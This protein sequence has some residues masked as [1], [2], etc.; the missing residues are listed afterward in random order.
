MRRL[1]SAAAGLVVAGGLLV[2]CNEPA[3]ADVR[4][5]IRYSG[6]PVYGQTAQEIWRDIGRK[7]PHQR[8]RGLYAQAEAEIGFGWEIA[9][10]SGG[11]ICRVE[12]ATVHADVNIILPQWVDEARGSE[13]LR[14]AWNS[15]IAEVRR[16]EDH[17]KD[18]ALV[19]AKEL[20]RAIMAA[21]AHRSCRALERY[22]QQA[23]DRILA[24]E[25]AQQTQFDRTDEPIMLTGGR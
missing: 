1:V 7:G 14:R 17:H 22:I 4:S 16:H 24:W 15:Y 2:I 19:A 10:A 9:Y 25:W 8:E 12:G 13:A 5:N 21:P 6:Y 3:D 20:D 11:G 18:I 23:A